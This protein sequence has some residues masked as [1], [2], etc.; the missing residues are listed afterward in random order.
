[1]DLIARMQ[2]QLAPEIFTPRA[3]YDGRKNLFAPR[4]LPFGNTDSRDVSCTARHDFSSSSKMS[5]VYLPSSQRERQSSHSKV[6]LGRKDK[7]RVS[8]I[9]VKSVTT[10]LTASQNTCSFLERTA[11]PRQHRTNSDYCESYSGKVLSALLMFFLGSRTFLN[12]STSAIM[13]DTTHKEYCYQGGTYPEPQ[14][15]DQRSFFLYRQGDQGHRRRPCALAR[16]LS[17]HPPSSR[18]HANQRRHFHRCYV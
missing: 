5:A 6:D 14:L 18:P 13:N 15:R 16:V 8:S 10:S 1:M 4:Q 17:V 12:R 7:P 9:G 2:T 3:V 11:E